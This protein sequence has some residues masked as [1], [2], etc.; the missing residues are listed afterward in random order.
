MEDFVSIKNWAVEDRP[1]EKA[2]AKGMDSLTNSEL[3]AIL[4]N[5]GT[6]KRSAIDIAK[7]LLN[8]ADYNLLELCKRNLSEITK[9]KG[10]G[11]KKAI[12]ILA[13]LELGKR[14]QITTSL[15]RPKVKTSKDSFQILSPYFIGLNVEHFYVAFLNRSNFVIEIQ[16]IS[17]GGTASTVVDPKVIFKK[18]LE[19]PTATTLIVAHNHPSG[20]LTPSH[21]DRILT[22]RLVDAAKVLDYKILDHLIISQNEFLSMADEGLMTIRD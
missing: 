5:T 6:A 22:Q 2:I 4:I 13:A 17:T 21:P 18:A 1:V 10:I 19:I 11:E 14:R 20:N 16:A 3:L 15:E 8:S 12:T 7:D 9:I